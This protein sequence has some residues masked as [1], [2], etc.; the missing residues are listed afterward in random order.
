MGLDQVCRYTGMGSYSST[1]R[2]PSYSAR[3][4]SVGGNAAS[5]SFMLLLPAALGVAVYF[6]GLPMWPDVDYYVG[7]ISLFPSPLGTV[8]GTLGGY[9]G[10]A[11]V[12]SVAAF[13]II[14]VV[15]LLAQELGTRPLVAQ[16][17]ALLVVP[18]TWF[19]TWGMD[20]PA[21]AMLLLGALLYLRGRSTWA[22][23]LGA[24]AAA[25]HLAALPL[26]AGAVLAQAR[27][28]GVLSGL[29]LL[30]LGAIVALLTPYGAAF[31][32]LSTPEALLEGARE[33][34][35]ACWPFVL[36]LLVMGLD[37]RVWRLLGGA[38]IG[39]IVAG[40]IP[41]A[42]GQAGLTRYAVPC[43]FLAVP[44]L[45]FRSFGRIRSQQGIRPQQEGDRQATGADD[46]VG[47]PGDVLQA[48]DPG[49]TRP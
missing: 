35:D 49:L 33:L 20:A 16:A 41:A 38:A 37:R 4:G 9:T 8:L 21:T 13:V 3:R 48:C 15:G 23:V 43:L 2:E 40:A 18:A 10:F 46:L 1:A 5:R 44:A 42:V 32:L 39:A 19:T 45:R 29:C 24:T 36:L 30:A 25:T 31:E 22:V 11:I 47:K 7:G 28:R 26:A 17:L 14:L 12:N 27:L 34:K 6:A